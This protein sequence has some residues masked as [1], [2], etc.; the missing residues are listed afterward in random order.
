MGIY[1]RF[2]LPRLLALAMRH[3][4]LVPYRQRVG[5][6][7]QGRVLEIGIGPGLNL[8]FYGQAVSEV[9]GIDPSPALL[10]MAETRRP[11]TMPSVEFLEGT[12][13]QLPVDSGS[14]DTVVTTCTLCSVSDPAQSSKRPGACSGAAASCCSS[15]MAGH[16][17]LASEHSRT[18]S[19]PSGST[20]RRCHLNRRIDSLVL[21]ASFQT[22]GLKTAY[23]RGPKPMAF[24][25]QGQASPR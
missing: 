23:L 7:A 6:A 20:S 12:A 4:D 21:E 25:D 2:V 11:K 18:A 13:E 14:V 22:D 9:L 8:P 10:A 15:S 16:S 1:N 19:R 24:M 17:R 5:W 3:G